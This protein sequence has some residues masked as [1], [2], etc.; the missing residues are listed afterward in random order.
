MATFDISFRSQSLTRPV[1]V[2]LIIPNDIPPMLRKGNPHYD[3]PMQTMILLHGYTAGR[4]EWPTFSPVLEL[5]GKYNLAI[6]CPDGGIRFYLDGKGTGAAWCRYVGEELPAYLRSTFGL[7]D[8]RANTFIAGESMGGFGALHTA[9]AWPE[10][11]R[12]AVALSS[13]LIIHQVA[14]M[15]PDSQP[16]NMA[17]YD[18]YETTF[19]DPSL[20]EASRRNPE[21]LVRELKAAGKR[22]PG[23]FMACGTEDFLLENNREFR[24]FLRREKVPVS[25]HE[26]PGT[27][28]FEF[29]NKWIEPGIVWALEQ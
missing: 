1:D 9:L 28:N 3:R 21:T 15:T 29:W 19:G 5:A 2:H 20:L 8:G 24:D 10:T 16:V 14:K 23:L 27:H 22:I 4:M 18:Y 25:Y 7:A 6:A 17:D 26:G 13:A 12:C 11:F